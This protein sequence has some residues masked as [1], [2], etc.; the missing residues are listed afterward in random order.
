MLFILLC[1]PFVCGLSIRGSGFSRNRRS[2]AS[3]CPRSQLGRCQARADIIVF[4]TAQPLVTGRIMIAIQG[5]NS[6]ATIAPI[7]APEL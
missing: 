6:G 5:T 1:T 4:G 7:I 2:R 3:H